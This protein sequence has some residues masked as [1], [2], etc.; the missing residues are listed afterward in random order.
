M[1]K[2]WIVHRHPQRRAALSRLSGLAAPDVFAAAPDATDFDSDD[3]DLH[4]GE[5]PAALLLCLEGDFEHELEFAHRHRTRLAR[6]R[7]IL[8]CDPRDAE[9]ARRLFD[10]SDIEILEAPPTSRT[11]RALVSSA[12]AQRRS[13]S[14]ADRRHRDR[15]S[16]RFSSWLAEVEI[17]GLL[18]ALDPALA[19]L[20]LLARGRAG[21]GRALLGRY[22]E[23]FRGAKGDLFRIHA[24]E[25]ASAEDLAHRIR[26]A[27]RRGATDARRDAPV[28]S[29]WIDEI[30]QLA[31][32]IQNALAEWI[33]HDTPPVSGVGFGLRFLA[34]AGPSGF[35]ERL[36]ISLERAFSPLSLEIPSLDSQ[37]GM[38][39]RFAEEIS[40]AWTAHVG[41]SERRFS[42]EAI[43]ALEA[44]PWSADRTEVEA[45]VRTSLAATSTALL[46]ASDLHFPG[47]AFISDAPASRPS[48]PSPPSQPSRPAA[49]RAPAPIPQRTTEA[50]HD[51]EDLSLELTSLSERVAAGEGRLEDSAQGEDDTPQRDPFSG[52]L[53]FSQAQPDEQAMPAD[54]DPALFTP[55]AGGSLETSGDFADFERAFDEGI[56]HTQATASAEAFP[57]AAPADASLLDSARNSAFD[58]APEPEEIR[59]ADESARL[60]ATVFD[61][62]A[63]SEGDPA[64]PSEDP[65]YENWRRLAR[66]LSHEIRNPLVSIR[67]FAELLPEHFEDATFRE[68]FTELVGKDV[69]TISDVL[70][71][72]SSVAERKELAPGSVD[73]STLIEG[74]LES[75]RDR[76]AEGRL[77]VLRELEREMPMAWADRQTLEVALAGLIDRALESLPERGDL[78]VAT[79][80]IERAA[81]GSPRLRVLLRHHNPDLQ[82]T[83]SGLAELDPAA[84]V[85][86]YVI[87]ETVV[88]ASGGTLTIDAADA[89]ETLILVDLRTPT[90]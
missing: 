39:R 70:T 21:S 17:P 90:A 35:E 43:E 79:R 78:F 80:H 15:I 85:L 88:E 62:N 8:L 77:L 65:G 68:R 19:N 66:S 44:Y 14:L 36:E 74:L 23:L 31:P 6:S 45:V 13:D 22:V 34:T 7:W 9:E 59:N 5:A 51:E 29:V 67:T 57:G 75:R 10:A 32:S 81:D 27:N 55:T 69:A 73:V 11:L 47:E 63:A 4:E 38:L 40:R 30:D 61:T 54:P 25:L 82:G 1:S 16:E 87:A 76:I 83:R 53:A 64:D 37:P 41:G 18:R 58:S 28:R 46:E 3:T 24:R 89:Q 33:V 56:A 48:R 26:E 2:L 71:R 86:E 20:P 84:N 52:H 49:E 72:L 12:V 50:A 42:P 60:A